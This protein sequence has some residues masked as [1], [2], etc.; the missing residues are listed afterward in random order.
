M[1]Y[2]FLWLHNAHHGAIPHLP[3]PPLHQPNPAPTPPLH[4]PHTNPTP[5]TY[6]LNT[7]PHHPNTTT[8]LLPNHPYIGLNDFPFFEL[9]NILLNWFLIFLIELIF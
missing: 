1:T 6:H 5:P 9:M 7:T 8:E 3:R 4:Y 2:P